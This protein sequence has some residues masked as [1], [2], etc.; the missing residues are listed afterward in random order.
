M[1]SSP[2]TMERFLLT[3]QSASEGSVTFRRDTESY[4][5][6]DRPGAA[7]SLPAQA[8]VGHSWYGQSQLV[9]SHLPFSLQSQNDVA[10]L[11]VQPI[12]NSGFAKCHAQLVLLK[13]FCK[14]NRSLEPRIFCLSCFQHRVIFLKFIYLAIGSFLSLH[15]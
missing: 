11:G 6:G 4:L 5:P 15:C 10:Y 1:K 14:Q 2:G 12:N 8:P 9:I 7:G 3:G 13:E